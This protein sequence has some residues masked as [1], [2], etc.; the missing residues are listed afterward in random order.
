MKCPTCGDQMIGPL[1]D[2]AFEAYWVFEC[3]DVEC[4]TEVR[5]LSR[6]GK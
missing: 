3:D 5:R 1:G 6:Y 2:S 4:E